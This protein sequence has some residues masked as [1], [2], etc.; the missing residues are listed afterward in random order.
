MSA[1]TRLLSRA[2]RTRPG[3]PMRTKSGVGENGWASATI[4]RDSYSVRCLL[5]PM[6]A[7]P[8]PP[9][10]TLSPPVP[11]PPI[12]GE[13]SLCAGLAGLPRLA[14]DWVGEGGDGKMPRR[15]VRNNAG[16]AETDMRDAAE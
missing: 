6:A 5:K 4:S 13:K 15:G 12:D 1:C 11:N 2:A 10:P 14:G 7:P 8:A 3:A 9:L 16:R